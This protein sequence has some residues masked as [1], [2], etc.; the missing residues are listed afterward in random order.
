MGLSPSHEMKSD[1]L[2]SEFFQPQC[3]LDLNYFNSLT[4]FA[5]HIA[6]IY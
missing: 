4:K 6:N 1:T 5:I 3:P 2:I